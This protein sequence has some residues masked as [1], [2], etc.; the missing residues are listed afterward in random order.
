M[1]TGADMEDLKLNKNDRFVIDNLFKYALNKQSLIEFDEYILESFNAF[2][3]NKQ[4]ILLDLCLL[5]EDGDDQIVNLLMHSME[6]NGKMREDDDF[7][8]LFRDD[9]LLLFPNAKSLTVD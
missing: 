9:L 1:M 7:T 2:R 4:E 3:Q 8:N 6:E 5:E